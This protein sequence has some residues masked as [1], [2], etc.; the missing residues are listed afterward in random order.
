METAH[1]NV[2]EGESMLC[3]AVKHK[4]GMYP[5]VGALIGSILGGPIGLYAGFKLGGLMGFGCGLLGEYNHCS[6]FQPRH[7]CN[8][9]PLKF[10]QHNKQ[11]PLFQPV[12]T[13]LYTRTKFYSTYVL[14]S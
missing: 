10:H 2:L 14:R 12:D 11:I 4:S 9:L 6:S 8:Y 7:L 3:K 13:V 5:L 1:N